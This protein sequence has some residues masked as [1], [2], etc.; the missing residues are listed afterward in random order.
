MATS[1]RHRP[2]HRVRRAAR[3][4]AAMGTAA[5]LALPGTADAYVVAAGDTLSGIAAAHGISASALASA[6][7]IADPDLVV[8]GATLLI[9]DGA[10]GTRA[11]THVVQ[12]GETLSQIAAQHGVTVGA[13][14]AANGIADPDHIRSGVALSVSGSGGAAAGSADPVGSTGTA[15]AS[16]DTVRALI[17][18]AA[19]RHGWRPA[20]PLGLAMQESGWNST[21]VSPAGA[22]GI[23]QVLPA[24]GEWVGQYLLG[25]TLDLRVPADNVAAGM[26][27]LDYLYGRF[28]GDTVL[29]LAAYYEGPRRVEDNGPSAGAERYA[30]NVLALAERYR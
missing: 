13:L 12:P 17:S 24:T 4:A 27:Y 1:T 21:V 28:R 23:M 7:D 3:V 11:S 25:R 9:P 29:A 22:I 10:G 5:V 19:V 15:R 8:A 16:D 26:A 30:A 14:A 2:H 6:N 18:D 20:V